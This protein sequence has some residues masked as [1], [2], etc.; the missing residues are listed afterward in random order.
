MTKK[1]KNRDDYPTLEAFLATLRHPGSGYAWKQGCRCEK[2]RD[3]Q[4]KAQ[5][6]YRAN[7]KRR[8]LD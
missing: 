2:C 6:R 8:G 1:R 5:R 3:W 4:R 7:R